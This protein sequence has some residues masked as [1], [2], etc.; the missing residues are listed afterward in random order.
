MKDTA[1]RFSYIGNQG[2]NLEQR[3]DLNNKEGWYNYVIRTGEARP[4]NTDLLRPNP[5]WA[6]KA[7]NKT[8][9]SNTHMAEINLERRF[10]KGVAFQTYYTFSRALTTTD[11]D[12]GAGG[13]QDINGD[14]RGFSVPQSNE[15][16]GEPNLTYAQ[17]QRLG[18]A[19]NP[20]IPQHRVSWNGVLDLPFGRG[21]HFGGNMSKLL[22]AVVGGWSLTPAGSW[23]SG[24]WL[25]VGESGNGETLWQFGDPTLSAD[26]RLTMNINGVNQRIWFKGSF[27]PT[28]ATNVDMQKLQQLMPVDPTQRVMRQLGNPGDGGW[29]QLPLKNGGTAWAP[30]DATYYYNLVSWNQRANIKGPG[31]WTADMG[32][33]K[34]FSIRES[35][36]LQIKADAFNFLNHPNDVNP[37]M[38]T[39]LQD[40]SMQA[41]EPRIF[42]F[43]ARLSF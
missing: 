24:L 17:R 14:P 30:L 15:I 9:Y 6:M 5:D 38:Y 22:D 21:R 33:N 4:G 25:T 2:R 23:R 41:N 35:T 20:S 28:Q 19:N 7:I 39:G 31:Y 12:A 36:K 43:L 42:Q 29:V 3:Y 16:L 1:L 26:E 18:Y 37:N 10:S 34:T 27:D 32:L 13:S 40:L 11:D 8:G